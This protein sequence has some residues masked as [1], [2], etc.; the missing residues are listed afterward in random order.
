[1]NKVS[2]SE[3]GLIAIDDWGNKILLLKHYKLLSAAKFIQQHVPLIKK[4]D[5][6]GTS[7]YNVSKVQRMPSRS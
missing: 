4:K 5:V 3:F 6:L 2:C 1:M 7:K